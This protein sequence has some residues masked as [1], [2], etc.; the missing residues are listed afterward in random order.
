MHFETIAEGFICRRKPTDENPTMSGPRIVIAKDGSLVAVF[1]MQSKLGINDFIPVVSRSKDNGL[2]WRDEGPIW[3]SKIGKFS[4]FVALSRDEKGD[5]YV[6]GSRY[7]ID[8]PGE[9]FWSEA[10]QGLKQNELIWAVSTD[11]GKSWSQPNV[12]PMP[13]PGSAEAPGPMI[14]TRAGTWVAPYSP[15]NTFDPNLKVDRGQV[16][17]VV[18]RDKGH[19][20][21]HTSM[22]RFA[23]PNSGAAE[24]WCYELSD[25]RM[26]GT[27]WHT[28][29]TAG[30]KRKDHPNKYAI[31]RDGG[32]TWSKTQST[33]TMGNTTA[34]A[35]FPDGRAL[36]IFV[37]RKPAEDVGIWAAV[38]EPTEKD[39]GIKHQQRV[40][41]VAK[42]TQKEG[43]A[44]SHEDWTGFNF[45]EPAAV[46][47]PN[48][49]LLLAYW[50]IAQEHS[51]IGTVRLR[52]VK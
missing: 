4:F 2:T 34:L 50:Y 9:S 35:A 29:Y 43:A 37:K 47:L 48:N 52:L 7:P 40:W 21:T 25:G 22:I 17:A 27:T 42:P 3:P 30:D 49:E 39:F 32:M 13:I 10:T 18:S 23:E 24:A 19:T 5:L 16:V 20:W 44:A 28:D 26:L 46:V 36:F 15:Y 38:A 8:T 11:H 33:G 31:S 41:S 14:I 45:G 12:I 51:G 6:F 1:M